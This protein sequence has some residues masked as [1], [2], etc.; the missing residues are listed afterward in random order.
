MNEE[1]DE[2][3]FSLSAGLL[4][5]ILPGLGQIK[6]GDFLR[7]KLIMLGVVGMFLMGVLVGGVDCVD[8]KEDGL[9]F[10]AQAGAGPIACMTDIANDML[11]KQGRVGVMMPLALANGAIT[12]VNS[13]K[14]VGAVNDIGTLFTAMAGLLNI[15]ALLD[16]MRGPRKVAA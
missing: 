3:T 1:V 12:Q 10:V 8:R 15:A 9:W 11:L 6:N 16:A 13:F 14:S 4:G 5:W 7:G 2:Q